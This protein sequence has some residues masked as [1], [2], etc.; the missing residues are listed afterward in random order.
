M[1]QNL[2]PKKYYF[3]YQTKN[4]VNGKTY[5]GVHGTNNLNDGYLGSGNKILYILQKYG[6][7][8]LKMEILCFFDTIEEAYEEEG[9]LVDKAWVKKRDNYN[10]TLGGKIPPSF[11]GKRVSDETKK[12]ISLK[13]SGKIRSLETRALISKIQKGRKCTN[14]ET[15]AKMSASMKGKNTGPKSVETI[16][17]I[18]QTK[19]LNPIVIS[20]ETRKKLSI[21]GKGRKVKS[22]SVQRMVNTRK[23]NE[24]PIYVTCVES[25]DLIGVF[26]SCMDIVRTLKISKCTVDRAVNG[27]V[28]EP[29]KYNIKRG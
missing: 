1:A 4:L 12:K 11:L 16:A 3:T 13:N 26:Y 23:L 15:L 20:E 7:D 8:Q 29:K 19:G 9:F 21:A 5:V 2:L 24:K 6:K 27:R 10:I 25:G 28:Q 14:P 17:K 22:E 18:K